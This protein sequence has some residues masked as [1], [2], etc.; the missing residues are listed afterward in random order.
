VEFDEQVSILQHSNVRLSNHDDD[1]PG[2]GL[3]RERVES[4]ERD[5][6]L[7]NQWVRSARPTLSI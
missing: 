5:S 4:A 6:S 1:L 7:V 2:L 3:L